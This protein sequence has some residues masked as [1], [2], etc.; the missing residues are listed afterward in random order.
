MF[1]GNCSL[2]KLF[3]IRQFFSLKQDYFHY[4]KS[5]SIF[6]FCYTSM[7]NHGHILIFHITCSFFMLIISI[8]SYTS[9]YKAD[10]IRLIMFL[11]W[12]TSLLIFTFFPIWSNKHELFQG[13]K[14]KS[15]IFHFFFISPLHLVWISVSETIEQYHGKV[16]FYLPRSRGKKFLSHHRPLSYWRY[17]YWYSLLWCWHFMKRPLQI[18]L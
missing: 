8:N 15:K 2:G 18:K 7:Y 4:S 1:L 11:K 12:E 6:I 13:S 9:L 10:K 17:M 16:F 14:K 5:P 3:S